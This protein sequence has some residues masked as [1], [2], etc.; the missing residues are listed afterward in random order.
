MIVAAS[1][2]T[3]LAVPAAMPSGR[4]VVSRITSTGLP[5]LGASSCTPP[6]SVSAKRQAANR[7]TNSEYGC[8]SIR[9]MFSVAPKRR[10]TTICTLGFRCTG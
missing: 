8:G 5:R 2:P 10:F 4:S 9:R 1:A 3:S 7:A 6:E